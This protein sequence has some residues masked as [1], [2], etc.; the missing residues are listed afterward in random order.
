[1][2]KLLITALLIASATG[3][4]QAWDDICST[5]AQ[6]KNLT[7]LQLSEYTDR[8]LLHRNFQGSGKVKD[9]WSGGGMTSKYTV[10]VD[11][12]NDVIV[13]LPTNAPKASTNLKR[14]E[15]VSFSGMVTGVYQENY[16]DT[17][18]EFILV[19]FNDNAKV[20]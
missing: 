15:Y 13:K 17:R 12:G 1:M 10:Q 19:N 3:Q 11:C 18:R 4:A 20:W 2:K 6:G 7:S 16:S 9:V 5:A 8:K 14:G